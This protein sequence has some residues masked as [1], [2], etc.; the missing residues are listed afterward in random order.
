M[1]SSWSKEMIYDLEYFYKSFRYKLEGENDLNK[2]IIE[3]Y[4]NLKFIDNGYAYYPILN[5]QEIRKIK[6]LI[7]K[8]DE[9]SELIKKILDN[10]ELVNDPQIE[11]VEKIL[12]DELSNSINKNIFSNL[13]KLK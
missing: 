3:Q 11:N 5:K 4:L 8:Q 12:V 9:V 10:S 13:M 1:N 2:N 7:I 6:L